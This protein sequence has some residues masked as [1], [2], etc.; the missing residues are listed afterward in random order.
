[1]MARLSNPGLTIA[2]F[3]INLGGIEAFAR[4]LPTTV[5]T[6]DAIERA[7]STSTNTTAAISESSDDDDNTATEILVATSQA[8]ATEAAAPKG[9][10]GPSILLG[11][12]TELRLQIVGYVLAGA[13]GPS[14]TTNTNPRSHALAD[15]TS[16]VAHDRTNRHDT[17][18]RA[19]RGVLQ[20]CHTLRVDALDVLFRD[21]TFFARM[22]PTFGLERF[23]RWL[24][25]M[26][27]DKEAMGVR[28]IQFGIEWAS[29]SRH[30]YT[31]TQITV[32]IHKG[33]VQAT[34]TG[35]YSIRNGVRKVDE[36]KAL[37]EGFVADRGVGKGLTAEEWLQVWAK[38]E[39]LSGTW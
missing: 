11:L 6:E 35:T 39:A 24:A 14:G 25:L 7:E 1:M 26:R 18:W 19:R 23:K 5:Q 4:L 30:R 2:N 13:A 38:I 31:R 9:K 10:T 8:I 32:D 16:S 34:Q 36:V 33:M 15:A 28:R 22:D 17:Q 12:P 29:G 27:D 37:V 21:G 20:A 3:P